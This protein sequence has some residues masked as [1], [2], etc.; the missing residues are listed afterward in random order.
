MQININHIRTSELR[1]NAEELTDQMNWVLEHKMFGLY[2]AYKQGR[3][4]I[5]AELCKR[6]ENSETYSNK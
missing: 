5:D 1:K 4:L 3:D 6:V 2:L